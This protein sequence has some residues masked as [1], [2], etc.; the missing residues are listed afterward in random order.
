MKIPYQG[1]KILALE[2]SLNAKKLKCEI[3]LKSILKAIT[4]KKDDKIVSDLISLRNNLLVDISMIE[5]QIH[6]INYK[7]KQYGH[8]LK[9]WNLREYID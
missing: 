9:E 3:T 4:D 1:K 8:E 5:K 7:S 2:K 6:N